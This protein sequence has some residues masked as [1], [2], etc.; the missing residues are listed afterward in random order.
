MDLYQLLR[1][2][3]LK[4]KRLFER[5]AETADGASKARQR[6]F[7]ELRQELELHTQVEEA[8]FYPALERHEEASELVEDA[9][10]EH[11]E[12]KQLL[13]A[14]DSADADED[15]WFD[16]LADLQEEV[17]AHVEEEE[18]RLFPVAQKLLQKPEADAIAQAIEQ[19]KAA[20]KAR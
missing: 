8:H 17:E 3:H 15:G 9:L 13:E 16:Q 4:A 14:L 1:Q 19:E 6:L 7:T 18:T 2:D 20:A 11:D 10:D 12:M 5:L